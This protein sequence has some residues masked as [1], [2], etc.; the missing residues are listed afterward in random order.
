MIK[1]D[2]DLVAS[3]EAVV[4]LGADLRIVSWN[5]AAEELT[6][7][8]ADEAL[9]QPCWLVLRGH[10]REGGVVCHRDC[11]LARYS[12]QGYGVP[13]REL[14]LQTADGPREVW[15]S[16][17]VVRDRADPLVVHL[18]QRRVES[19]AAEEAQTSPARLTGR[20]QQVL[21]LLADGVPAR[22]IADRLGIAEATVRNHIRSILRE[23]EVHSQLEAVARGRAHGLV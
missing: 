14:F 8:A 18:F 5:D 12:V 22:E 16:T 3:G 17:F 21:H 2:R 23:L 15:M 13:A 19:A 6:G 20:Q 1:R 11:S 10:D 9:G 7:I 4:A